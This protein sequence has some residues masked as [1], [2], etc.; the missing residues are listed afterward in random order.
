MAKKKNKKRLSA[1]WFWAKHLSLGAILVWAAYYFL[2][3]NIPKME[4]KE[5]TNAAA[6]GLSQFYANF[7]DRMNERD[8]E[9][10]KFVVEIGKPTFP[11]DDALAQRELVV[12][13]TNQRWTGESQP[14]R[15]KM[16][17][18]LKSVLTNYAKQ[19]DI[20]L[21]W[22]L[23]KDYV[24][25]QNFRVDS[26]FVSALYQVG[27]AINDDFEFEVYT[28]FCHRQRAAVITENPSIFVR[29]NCR[30]LTN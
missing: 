7:R 6:Q 3:G 28:F 20:E 1:M 18:T 13:P 25:K 12:K 8:T 2:Y 22:Y 26:D 14:R 17:N 24:V 27:R 29:E 11:L 21:F 5:T 23:S 9:R 19:E 30:R 15:F 10:E 16:G 4:F